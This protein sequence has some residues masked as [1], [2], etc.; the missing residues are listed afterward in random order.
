MKRNK[1][2]KEKNHKKE[3]KNKKIRNLLKEEKIH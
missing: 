2:K 1:T 3:Y